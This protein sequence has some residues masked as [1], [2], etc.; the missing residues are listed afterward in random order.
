M[1]TLYIYISINFIRQTIKTPDFTLRCASCR[2]DDLSDVILFDTF[3]DILYIYI[4]YICNI[5]IINIY[6]F[7]IHV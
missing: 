5:C 2:T 6:G 7:I 4:I 3:R 1:C